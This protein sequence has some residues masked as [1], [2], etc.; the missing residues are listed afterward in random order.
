MSCSVG[1]GVVEK[2]EGASMKVRGEA[3]VG[4]RLFG[5]RDFLERCFD[6]L[7]SRQGTK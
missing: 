3:R 2:G 6:L 5:S 4:G 1:V 7:L